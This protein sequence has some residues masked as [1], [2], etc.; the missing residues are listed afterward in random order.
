VKFI[1]W[2]GKNSVLKKYKLATMVQPFYPFDNSDNVQDLGTSTSRF[3]DLYL[4]GQI[5]GPTLTLPTS[6]PAN[7][8]AGTAVFDIKAKQLLLFDGK[9]WQTISVDAPVTQPTNPPT[10]APSTTPKI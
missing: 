9:T 1:V 8:I 7:P 6:K 5:I 4:S 10:A 2:C 3:K